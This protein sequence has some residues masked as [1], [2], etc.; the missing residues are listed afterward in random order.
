MRYNAIEIRPR[1]CINSVLKNFPAK[2]FPEIK[3]LNLSFLAIYFFINL[4]YISNFNQDNRYLET[5]FSPQISNST[6]YMKVDSNCSIWTY[7]HFIVFDLCQAGFFL[8][9]LSQAVRPSKQESQK[10]THGHIIT[11]LNLSRG[12]LWSLTECNKEKIAHEP[13]HNEKKRQGFGIQNAN[14][15]HCTSKFLLLSI[16]LPLL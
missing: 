4:A 13:P 2:E 12:Q 15:H 10:K 5:Q 6:A 14:D 7:L 11:Y 3:S 9:I 8:S 16:R 1:N